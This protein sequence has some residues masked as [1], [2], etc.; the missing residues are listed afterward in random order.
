MFVDCT[1]RPLTVSGGQW[2]AVTM[3]GANLSRLDLSGVLL[4]E[5]DL[6][7]ANLTGS[8]LVGCDLSRAVLREADLRDADLRGATLHGVDLRDARLGSTR[9][10]LAG[11]VAV[12]EQLGAVVS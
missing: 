5:A 7:D 12:A 3:R 11:A 1:L 2:R 4:V 10:D 6:A 8:T 9:L